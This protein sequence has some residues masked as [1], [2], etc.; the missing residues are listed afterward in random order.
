[1]SDNE[2]RP[3]SYRSGRINPGRSG[4]LYS[5]PESYT[6]LPREVRPQ[7]SSGKADKKPRI[8]GGL[9]IV[10]RTYLPVPFRLEVSGL[11]MALSLTLNDPVLVPFCVGV[12]TTLIVHEVL[13]ARLAVQ[14][15]AD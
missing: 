6:I 10:R 9:F 2:R 14:V 1:L 11:L 8:S 12:N 7:R 15:V 5:P 4:A 13:A 3:I